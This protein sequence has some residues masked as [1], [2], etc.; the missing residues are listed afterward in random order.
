MKSKAK[1]LNCAV[2]VEAVVLGQGSDATSETTC[3]YCIGRG[4]AAPRSELGGQN[5]H[6]EYSTRC[7]GNSKRVG[8][9]IQKG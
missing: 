2:D 3:E 7:A 8:T 6:E 4:S 5:A 1:E 9:E